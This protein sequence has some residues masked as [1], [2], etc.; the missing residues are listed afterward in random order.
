MATPPLLHQGMRRTIQCLQEQLQLVAMET[1][2]DFSHL[3]SASRSL[4][5]PTEDLQE[6]ISRSV[7]SA[8]LCRRNASE[9]SCCPHAGFGL[10]AVAALW[11]ARVRSRLTS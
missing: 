9:L 7:S 8:F 6:K 10:A 3:S 2:E 11:S 4:Q 5:E 1:Q